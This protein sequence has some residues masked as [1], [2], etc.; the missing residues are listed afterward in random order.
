MRVCAV[1]CVHDDNEFLAPTL[2]S[3]GTVDTIV[4]VSR[5]DWTGK[6]GE[7]EQTAAIASELGAQVV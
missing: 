7:W 5:V 6:E 4:C 2:R 1:L 3:L